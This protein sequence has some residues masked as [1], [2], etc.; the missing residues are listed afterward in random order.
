MNVFWAAGAL[1]G[2]LHTGS[3]DSQGSVDCRDEEPPETS[4]N[5]LKRLLVGSGL[6]E[7][8]SS[9]ASSLDISGCLGGAGKRPITRPKTQNE[10][11][12]I[13]NRASMLKCEC[14]LIDTF[15]ARLC[16]E[17]PAFQFVLQLTF[18]F[19]DDLGLLLPHIS[20]LLKVFY[21]IKCVKLVTR[22]Q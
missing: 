19:G 10:P 14:I 21:Q 3:W 1:K 18:T 8:R 4:W 20:H 5:L 12:S 13:P 17:G 9:A 11:G 22:M 2:D 16:S 15:E 6:T 7:V